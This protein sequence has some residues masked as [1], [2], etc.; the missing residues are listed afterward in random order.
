MEK[1]IHPVLREYGSQMFYTGSNYEHTGLQ[2][3][4][5]YDIQFCVKMPT[6]RYNNLLLVSDKPQTV[7]LD[8]YPGWVRIEGGP[9]ELVDECGFLSTY[10]VCSTPPSPP[11][12]PTPYPAHYHYTSE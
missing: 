6:K 3:S 11:L 10:K 2:K 5:D 8:D 12:L 9:P 1:F 7:G 4:S